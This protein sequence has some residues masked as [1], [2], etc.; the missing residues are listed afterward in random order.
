MSHQYS[1]AFLLHSSKFYSL[2]IFSWWTKLVNH[3]GWYSVSN[4]FSQFSSFTM[5]SLV[6]CQCQVLRH[7]QDMQATVMRCTIISPTHGIAPPNLLLTFNALAHISLKRMT[8]TLSLWKVCESTSLSCISFGFDKVPKAVKPLILHFGGH[9][10]RLVLL[11]G[12]TQVSNCDRVSEM[13]LLL[14]GKRGIYR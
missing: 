10:H 1:K 13:K 9:C 8:F 4:Y 12:Y 7:Y 3:R 5:F 11:T 14:M 6:L 2:S